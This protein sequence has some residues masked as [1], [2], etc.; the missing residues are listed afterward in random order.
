MPPRK[1][2][3]A[4]IVCLLVFVA[5]PNAYGQS[6][7]IVSG[8]VTDATGSAVAGAKVIVSAPA[9]GLTREATTDESGH[10]LVPLLPV[11]NFTIRV[12]FSG[13]QPA[14]QKDVRL[15]VDEHRELDFK[16]VPLR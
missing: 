16:L 1:L 11:A 15:Q 10:F 7:G 3:F 4:A 8:T 13:F 9:L 6:T 5:Y 2:L 12:E 14:E